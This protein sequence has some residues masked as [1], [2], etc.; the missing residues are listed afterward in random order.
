MARSVKD[1]PLRK[2]LEFIDQTMS[3]T[4]ARLPVG[5][6]GLT[7]LQPSKVQ[8]PWLVCDGRPVSR[9]TYRDLFSA[10]GTQFGVGDGSTTFNLPDARNVWPLGTPPRSLA[11]QVGQVLYAP[12]VQA[13][14]ARYLTPVILAR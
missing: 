7:Y 8:E 13:L 14:N 12:G 1:T 5:M 11:G 2:T 6:Y 9:A 10:I 4:T 3:S